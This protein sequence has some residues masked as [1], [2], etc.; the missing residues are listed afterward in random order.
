MVPPRR[1]SQLQLIPLPEQDP[2]HARH[3]P[4]VAE[5]LRPAR[6]T[7]EPPPDRHLQQVHLYDLGTGKGHGASGS[8][9]PC[10][11]RPHR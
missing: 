11:L 5:G 10:P 6:Q 8:R 7:E 1:L 2:S 4:E 9:G 3:V